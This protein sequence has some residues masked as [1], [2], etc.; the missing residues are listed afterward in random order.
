MRPRPRSE[1]CA[2][3]G[4][5]NA[6]GKE[7]VSPQTSPDVSSFGSSRL[8]EAALA[9]TAANPRGARAST[10]GVRAAGARARCPP[11]RARA[12]SGTRGATH[13]SAAARIVA[14]IT[15]ARPRSMYPRN[16]RSLE[17]HAVL[18]FGET[19]A[20]KSAREVRRGARKKNSVAPSNAFARRERRPERHARQSLARVRG[21]VSNSASQQSA[22]R[23]LESVSSFQTRTRTRLETR[24]TTRASEA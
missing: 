20:R 13:P 24:R 2:T 4:C 7:A 14:A 9:G 12:A 17:R 19:R 8:G 6:V 5:A 11:R 16:P 15:T 3:Y 1:G 21:P 10:H 18:S 22:S 23:L